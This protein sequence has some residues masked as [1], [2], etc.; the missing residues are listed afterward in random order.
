M[1]ARASSYDDR[2]Y[3]LLPNS[4]QTFHNFPLP[5]PV[6]STMRWRSAQYKLSALLPH[7]FIACVTLAAY[8]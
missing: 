3:L 4:I 2:L 5:G 8:S 6:K 1:R 7:G